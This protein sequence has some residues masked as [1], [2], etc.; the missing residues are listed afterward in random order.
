MAAAAAAGAG[1]WGGGGGGKQGGGGPLVSSGTETKKGY[2]IRGGGAAKGPH[3]P[4]CRDVFGDTAILGDRRWAGA[5]GVDADFVAGEHC[6]IA[7]IPTRHI[8]ARPP[9]PR[10]EGEGRGRERKRE[11]GREGGRV[12]VQN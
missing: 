2:C 4:L 11:G 6:S 7:R 3:V 5:Y 10:E 1:V 8:Q 9:S 12:K